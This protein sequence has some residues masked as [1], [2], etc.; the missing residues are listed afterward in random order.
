[1]IE[2]FTVFKLAMTIHNVLQPI[3]LNG[4][5]GRNLSLQTLTQW[6]LCHQH[7]ATMHCDKS[8]HIQSMQ[9]IT[10]ELAA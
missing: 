5:R 8:T 3:S 4:L 9:M 7:I 6:Y 2:S 1:M 10:A